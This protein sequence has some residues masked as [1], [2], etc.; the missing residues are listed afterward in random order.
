MWVASGPH[1]SHTGYHDTTRE[2]HCPDTTN[3]AFDECIAVGVG[4]SY[5]FIFQKTGTWPYHNHVSAG[6]FGKVIVQ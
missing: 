6:D 3:T 4:Q 1:P 5:S 2:Q